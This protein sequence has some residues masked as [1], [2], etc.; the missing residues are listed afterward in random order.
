MI[1][2]LLELF[3]HKQDNLELSHLSECLDGLACFSGESLCAETQ[4]APESEHW[5]TNL[6][7][8]FGVGLCDDQVILIVFILSILLKDNLCYFLEAEDPQLLPY[9]LNKFLFNGI[10]LLYPPLNSQIS[11]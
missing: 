2:V 7:W 8:C 9:L 5:L 11:S 6:W 3:Y 4:I 1:D 10:M